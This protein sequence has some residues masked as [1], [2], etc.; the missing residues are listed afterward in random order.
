MKIRYLI[1]VLCLFFLSDFVFAQKYNGR[2][3][4][5]LEY[6]GP[7]ENQKYLYG[8]E[9]ILYAHFAEKINKVFP[10]AKVSDHKKIGKLLDFEREKFFKGT[11]PY[12]FSQ[13]AEISKSYDVDFLVSAELGTLPGEQFIVSMSCIPYRT[14]E[15]FPVARSSQRCSFSK[16]SQGE[17]IKKIDE[18]I[19][20]IINKLKECEICPYY[21][22]VTIEV[23]SNREESE[24]FQIGSPCDID[25][26]TVTATRKTTS[27]LKWELN[28]YSLRAADG[29]VKYDLNENYTTVTN[30]PCYKCKNGDQGPTIVTETSETEAKTEGLSSE[31]TSEGKPTKDARIK[32]TFFENGTY[33]VLVK[34]TSKEG[35]MKVTTE[36]KFEGM[37]E[38]ESEPKDTKDKRINV[39][40]DVVLGPYKGTIKD[41]TLHQKE[42]KDLS[43]GK[44][45]TTVNIDFTLTR[46]D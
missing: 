10:C 38:S 35:P 9:D 4:I 27:T 20:E 19:D 36:K 2:F 29:T 42:T 15:K 25:Q 24:T 12:D 14:K 13:N 28:K 39:P 41:K 7:D 21:G 18:S 43:N 31:S 34:A 23:K 3:F 16:T 33:T 22:P 45:K 40:I 1:I 26:A 44:E 11:D 37:C 5:V 32:I 6:K 30:F 46:N 8:L 17:M